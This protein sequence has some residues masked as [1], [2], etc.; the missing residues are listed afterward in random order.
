MSIDTETRSARS[1]YR[2]VE[3]RTWG[4]EKFRALSPM[5]PSGQ[6]LWLYLITGP[7][8]GPIPGLFRAGRAAMAEELDWELEAFDKAFAE[9]FRQGMVKADFKARVVW[10]PKAI[11]HNRPES[12]NVVRSWAAE[13]DLIPECALKS[14]ALECLRTFVCKLGEG[15][16]KAFDEA[17]GKP[18][19]KPSPKAMPNQEQEQ[20]QEQEEASSLRSESSPQLTLTGDHPP[21]A[22]LKA[23][24]ASRIRRIA[25]DAQAAFNATLAKPNGVL[26]KCTVL[27][28][29]RLKAVEDCLPTVRQLCQQRTGSERVT[30]EFWTALF[31]TAADDEFHSGRQPGGAGHENWKPDFEYLLREK[32]IAKLFDRAMTENAA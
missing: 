9:A 2:K 28:K 4:D 1:R 31:E 32:V 19:G 13:F 27:N 15:F 25:E 3:V 24:R 16:A 7:H 23:K 17:F 26:A 30:P 5:P 10:I 14:E 12:P 11:Q 22:D 21:P 8:T 20:E 6:G 18:S 29:P